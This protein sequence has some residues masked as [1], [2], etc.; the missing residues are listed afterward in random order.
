SK[1]IINFVRDGQKAGAIGM[2]NTTWD[3]D[4]ESLFEMAWHPIVLGAAASWQEGVVEIQQFDRDFDWAFF[5]NDGDQF[6]K[7]ERA[8]GSVSPSIGPGTTDE[9]LWRDSFI[10]HFKNQGRGMAARIRTIGTSLKYEN[11]TL[12]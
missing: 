4:G 5:R 7:A 8:L 6:V 9:I 12:L 10:T 11:A 3:D 2:M 1:N